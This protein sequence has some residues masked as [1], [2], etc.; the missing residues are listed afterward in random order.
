MVKVITGIL[1]CVTIVLMAVVTSGCA[2]AEGDLDNPVKTVAEHG[3]KGVALK[4]E[5]QEYD[6]D[7]P[8]PMGIE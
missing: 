4:G 8:N 2:T 6:R 7:N 5:L 1:I 3:A